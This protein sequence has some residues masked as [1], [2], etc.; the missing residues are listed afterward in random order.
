MSPAK[1]EKTEYNFATSFSFYIIMPTSLDIHCVDD[2]G[3]PKNGQRSASV[4]STSVKWDMNVLLDTHC[5]DETEDLPVQWT[6]EWKSI[7]VQ[8]YVH[9]FQPPRLVKLAL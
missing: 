2:L 8:S 1:L 9:Y 5:E 7:S 4:Q 3:I 6:V